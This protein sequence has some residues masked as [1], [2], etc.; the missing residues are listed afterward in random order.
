[1]GIVLASPETN[2]D[3]PSAF[4]FVRLNLSASNNPAPN[5]R[6]PRVAAMIAICGTVK[7]LTFECGMFILALEISR[8]SNC[9]NAFETT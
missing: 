2:S 5:P 9:V 6:A 7:V 3:Q 4:R 8:V 1:M